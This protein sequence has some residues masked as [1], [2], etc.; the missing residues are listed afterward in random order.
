MPRAITPTTFRSVLC[1]VDFSPN[2]R[3]AL[4]YAAM[5][6]RLSDA[7]LVVL[8]VDDPL[9]AVAAAS[10]PNARMLVESR[11]EDLR[12]FVARA[13]RSATPPVQTTLLT[14]AGKPAREI[15]R[16]AQRHGCDLIV[17]GY[18]GIGRASRLLFGSTT[19]AV[20]RASAVPVVAVP[21]PRRSARLP[22]AGQGRLRR[23]S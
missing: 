19:E 4:R 7:H 1:P 18:R 17:M 3:S 12:R 9:L 22:V 10:R 23:A 6:A 11:Q 5:L 2:S 20:V 21:P 13:L 15:E 14:L 16:A 8:Y